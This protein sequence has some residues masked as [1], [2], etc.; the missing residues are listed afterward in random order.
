MK[1]TR[2]CPLDSSAFGSAL[3]YQ[4]FMGSFM[5]VIAA[6][7]ILFFCR[8]SDSQ[9]VFPRQIPPR[10]LEIKKKN[11]NKTPLYF[12]ARSPHLAVQSNTDCLLNLEVP[13][14]SLTHINR[15]LCCPPRRVCHLSLCL[16]LCK[17]DRKTYGRLNK[18]R[19]SMVSLSAPPWGNV[20][21]MRRA[22]VRPCVC[23][24]FPCVR[25]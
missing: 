25:P 13:S 23:T 20:S 15:P 12:S 22:R 8:E 18:R 10:R 3:C 24:R 16:S 19:H 2:R 14:H 6:L 7:F 5:F 11:Q 1:I 4:D 21:F 9:A 17:P